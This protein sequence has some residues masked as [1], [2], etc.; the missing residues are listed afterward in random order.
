[1]NA[2]TVGGPTDQ[3]TA[4]KHY[5]L[6]FLKGGGHKNHHLIKLDIRHHCLLAVN[7]QR[8]QNGPIQAVLQTNENIAIFPSLNHL[9]TF[10]TLTI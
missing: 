10:F 6:P 5:A 4:A 7:L 9:Y 3:Q 2:E 1:M 8:H